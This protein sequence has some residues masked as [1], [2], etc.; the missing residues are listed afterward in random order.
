MN[1]ISI[2]ESLKKIL[3]YKLVLLFIFG[4]SI[5]GSFVY[6]YLYLDNNYITKLVIKESEI[7]KSINEIDREL[8]NIENDTF[9]IKKNSDKTEDAQNLL[10]E[11]K[12]KPNYLSSLYL[13]LSNKKN[14]YDKY[15]KNTQIENQISYSKFLTKFKVRYDRGDKIDSNNILPGIFID[16]ELGEKIDLNF[17]KIIDDYNIKYIV[18]LNEKNKLKYNQISQNIDLD[19]ETSKMALEKK[20]EIINNEYSIANDILTKNNVKISEDLFLI[21]NEQGELIAFRNEYANLIT[22]IRFELTELEQFYRSMNAKIKNAFLPINKL[23]SSIDTKS[24]N[25][26]ITNIVRSTSLLKFIIFSLI[27]FFILTSIFF[28]F[29]YLNHLNKR[30]N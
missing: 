18:Y 8:S 1:E 12:T 29:L 6:S 20:L 10:K 3:N 11:K 22:D 16:F 30:L 4:C 25:I 5:L 21:F 26:E 15:I 7:S 17:Y 13:T 9:K 24:N 23:L 28:L 14:I 27:I 2:E 19:F